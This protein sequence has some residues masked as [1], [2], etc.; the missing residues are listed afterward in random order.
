MLDL[1]ANVG[2]FID[3]C[4]CCGL[5]SEADAHVEV[6][7]LVDLVLAILDASLL[8]GA[9]RR[10]VVRVDAVEVALAE[11]EGRQGC[12]LQSFTFVLGV[13]GPRSH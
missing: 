6:K 1:H 10:E 9:L 13:L 8:C 11:E 5:L 4:T 2:G 3:C 12:L 7:A